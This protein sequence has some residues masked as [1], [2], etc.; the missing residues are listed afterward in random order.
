MLNLKKIYTKNSTFMPI[1]INNSPD[2]QIFEV[3][4]RINNFR[5]R[6]AI[7]KKILLGWSLRVVIGLVTKQSHIFQLWEAHNRRSDSI[8]VKI[9][10]W[11]CWG[12]GTGCIHSVVVTPV[13]F[14]TPRRPEKKKY[15]LILCI[16]SFLIGAMSQEMCYRKMYILW[17]PWATQLP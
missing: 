3:R 17:L 7:T 1:H 14:I 4:M 11:T 5:G 9:L 10:A 15:F 12:E 6:L 16:D 13:W 2:C 8:V